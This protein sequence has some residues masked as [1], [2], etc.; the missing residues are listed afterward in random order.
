MRRRERLAALPKI[1]SVRRQRFANPF[2]H[3]VAAATERDDTREVRDVGAPVLVLVLLIDDDVFAR[4][5]FSKPLAL[6]MLPRVPTGT[7]SL[8]LP[9]TTILAS[10]SGC[11][12]I[13]WCPR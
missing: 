4:R 7:V 6:R 5:R 3:L 8:S 13:S 1:L 9:A 11:A 12:Q 10:L 2:A